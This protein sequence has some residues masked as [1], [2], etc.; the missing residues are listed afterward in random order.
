MEGVE[1]FD[2]A[3]CL[4]EKNKC[5]RCKR[6]IKK[7]TSLENVR[8]KMSLFE[9]YQKNRHL[10]HICVFVAL[11]AFYAIG[12]TVFSILTQ[13]HEDPCY[14]PEYL[15][16]EELYKLGKGIPI[17]CDPTKCLST[18]GCDKQ[19]EDNGQYTVWSDR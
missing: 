19:E 12:F 3:V 11:V 9:S 4:K 6:K 2:C 5:P 15:S 16:I 7:I 13:N 14:Q 17:P 8:V 1:F 18:E 10:F